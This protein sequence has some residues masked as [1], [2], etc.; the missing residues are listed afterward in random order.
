MLL[1]GVGNPFQVLQVVITSVLGLFAIGAALNGHL[2][3]R[4]PAV[5]RIV[6]VAAGLMMMV[7]GTLTDVAGLVV[8]GAIFL[9]MK[10]LA[11]RKPATV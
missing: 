7:P 8:I 6:L 2:F 10:V 3:R 9:L 4:I 11:D 1:E 5:L